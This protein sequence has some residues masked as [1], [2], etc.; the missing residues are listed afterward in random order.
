MDPDIYKKNILILG[1]SGLI[2]TR[3]RQQL[4]VANHSVHTASIRLTHRDPKQLDNL[5]S[6]IRHRNIGVIINCAAMLGM[7]Q[8]RLSPDIADIVNA[9]LPGELAKLAEAEGVQFFHVSSEAVFQS[10]PDGGTYAVSDEPM[11]ETVYGKTK[12][13]GEINVLKTGAHSVIRLPRVFDHERQI[14]PAL[15]NQLAEKGYVK[16]A[17]DVFSTPVFSDYAAHGILSVVQ[18]CLDGGAA[19]KKILHIGGNERV[20]LFQLM[21][22]LA[23]E[24]QLSKIA[25]VESAFFENNKE[26]KPFLHGGLTPCFGYGFDLKTAIDKFKLYRQMA[27]Q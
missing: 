16:V 19:S 6:Q 18:K 9:W 24:A 15:F 21:I 10:H 13:L 1:A 2:G 14:I 12:R 27:R 3:L 7:K 11:P 5:R 4:K 17:N 25:P 8:C 23:E 22:M 26:E 20:S